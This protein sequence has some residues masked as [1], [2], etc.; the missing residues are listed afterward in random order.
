MPTYSECMFFAEKTSAHKG[1]T[2]AGTVLVL[3]RKLTPEMQNGTTVKAIGV[4]RGDAKAVPVAT[5]VSLKYLTRSC[6]Q[7]TEEEARQLQPKMFAALE[8]YDRAPEYRTSHAL[9]V[10]GAVR[11]GTYSLQPADDQVLRALGVSSPVETATGFE[12]R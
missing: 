2:L 1:A 10:A 9:T 12:H 8:A 5:W 11:R 4:P 6:V 7:V 3:A